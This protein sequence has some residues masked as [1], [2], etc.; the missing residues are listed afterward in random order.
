MEEFDLVV[1]GSGTSATSA[2]D[3]CL[4]AKW[5]IAVIDQKPVGGTCALRGC[6][7]KKVL[8]S[9]VNALEY[10]QRMAGSGLG[11][12]GANINWPELIQFKRT[13]TEPMSKGIESSLKE[14][15]VEVI[16]GQAKFVDGHTIRVGDREL[17]SKKFLISA[18][19]QAAS[20]GF[21]GEEFL[22]DNE[23]FL[24]IEQLPKNIVFIGGGYISVEFAHIARMSGASVTILQRGSRLLVN[25]DEEMSKHVENSLTDIGA[26]ILLN[27]TVG[28]VVRSGS[29]FVVHAQS[30][31]GEKEVP[32][33]L[34]VHGAGREFVPS[35]DPEKA[36]I[37]WSRKGIEV[38]SSLQSV[39]NRDVYA[40]G[41]AA[42]TQGY[43][44]TPVANLEGR[45]A[46][47]N[48][49]NGSSL[50]PDYEAIPTVVFS[51]PPL[52]RVGLDEVTARR[53]GLNFRVNKGEMSSWYNSRRRNI[54]HAAYKFLIE[55]G[56]DKIL[57]AHIM[58][59]NAEETINL[60]AL[61]MRTGVKASDLSQMAFSYPSDSYDLKYMLA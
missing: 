8:L 46:A 51:G 61:A 34:V 18:G 36:G 41:D 48:M 24:A 25:F 12:V 6:D 19:V 58:G 49:V 13:F 59:E 2:V 22:V 1:I 35:M 16:N 7:P 10:A 45:T 9:A 17:Q 30:P 28:R 54:K 55:H 39:S 15:G 23:G 32:A 44:L 5:H 3:I 60:I 26:T 57:G 11:G 43:K 27:C 38:N 37:K 52:A 50:V 47:L 31:E 14:R 40:A 29:G 53:Q 21:P 33:D 20:S 42:D 4:D 56:S